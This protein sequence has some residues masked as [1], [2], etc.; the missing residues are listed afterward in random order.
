MPRLAH[1]GDSRVGCRFRS[2]IPGNPGVTPGKSGE[3]PCGNAK[4]P[5]KLARLDRRNVELR[6][7]SAKFSASKPLISFGNQGF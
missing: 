5:P 1:S 6:R 7:G 3:I 2:E 4:I